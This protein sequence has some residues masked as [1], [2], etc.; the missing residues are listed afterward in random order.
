MNKNEL[1]S[2]VAEKSEVTK[3]DVDKVL[4]ALV[5]VMSEDLA[6]G[7]RIQLPD[8]GSFK[9]NERNARTV[10]N[11]RTGEQMTSPACKVVKFTPAK[12]LK[13]SVNK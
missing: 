10:R 9:C 6:E 3:K 7:G 13:E 1:V 2:A 5:A 11:P 8:L 4:K 12:A